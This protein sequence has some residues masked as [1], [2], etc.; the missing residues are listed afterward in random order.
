MNINLHLLTAYQQYIDKLS[1]RAVQ[2]F[3]Q[4]LYIYCHN[5]QTHQRVWLPL[6]EFTYN[7]MTTTTY[8]PR[9]YRS[10]YGFDQ[11]TVYL[12]NNYELC[13]L[14]IEEQ[15]EQIN[16]VHK[17]SSNVHK[18]INHEQS[19]L[20]IKKATEVNINDLV[21]V[22]RQSLPIKPGNNK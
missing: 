12:H 1:E 16:I 17:Y 10:L 22:D 20:H 11:Q 13:S 21:L 18:C 8:K 7:T 19:S 9:P 15:R 6:P 5:Q 4:C 2:I 14:T 3:K